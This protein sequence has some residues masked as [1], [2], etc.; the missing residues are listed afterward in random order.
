MEK[1][2][3]KMA[4][5]YMNIQITKDVTFLFIHQNEQ[6]EKA[7]K[8][9]TECYLWKEEGLLTLL[10]GMEMGSTQ[11]LPL[12][13]PVPLYLPEGNTPMVP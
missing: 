8:N 7:G 13:L 1:E 5:T 3:L 10:V 12:C 6:T 4:S 11:R 2:I 9:D